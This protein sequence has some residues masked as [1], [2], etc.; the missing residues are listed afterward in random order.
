MSE[1]DALDGVAI[2]GMAGRFPRARDVEELWELLRTGTDAISYFSREE[3]EGE[4]VPAVVLDDPKYVR[5]RG[6]L[7]EAD[8]FDAAFFDCSPLEASLIDPQHRLFLEC[9]WHALESAGCDPRRAE[10]PIVPRSRVFLP[11]KTMS[12]LPAS[13]A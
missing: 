12:A 7:D 2:V 5:A 3:L 8:L 11:V 6:V 1:R 13:D 4:G 10:G 9:A